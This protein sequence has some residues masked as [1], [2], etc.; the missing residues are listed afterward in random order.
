[1]KYQIVCLD[2]GSIVNDFKD[3]YRKG[4][5]CQKCGSIFVD[6][7][8][9]ATKDNLL[10]AL[11]DGSL[12][13]KGIWRYFDFLPLN[14]SNHQVSAGEG[15]VAVE[16]WPFLEDIAAKCG[17][18]IEVYAHRHDNNPATGT[19]KDLAGA[20]I[21]SVLK[22]AGVRSYAV[23]TTGNIGVALSRYLADADVSLHVFV[24]ENSSTL[25]DAEISCFGQKVFRVRGDYSDAKKMAAGFAKKYEIPL[26]PN[27]YDP[28][29]IEAKKTIAYEWY[30]QLEDF[31]TVYIQA[32]SGGTGPLGI[33]KG[34]KDL[35]E[36]GLINS[37][38]RFLMV[39]SDCCNPMEVSWNAAKQSGFKDG[40]EN[41]YSVISNPATTIPTLATGNPMLYPRVATLAK[42]SGGEILSYSESAIVD[43]ARFIAYEVAVRIGP[44]AAI[45]VGGFFNA[46]NRGYLRDGDRIVIAIGEGIRRSPQFMES[47]T[48]TSNTV[49]D[50]SD[51]YAVSRSDYG[52]MLKERIADLHNLPSITG[53]S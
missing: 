8:Y 39:Q 29:R 38:P 2:C 27:S 18:N 6:V 11:E 41:D 33:S 47:L 32:L 42:D 45:G 52:K 24:P 34:C 36:M 16:R 25:H 12:S 53:N 50:L 35:V 26:S 43:I 20:A 7:T 15:C 51:C 4:Q 30:R 23:A 14:S 17:L 37:I 28:I 48:Y 9:S 46:L 10:S 19:F 40:W 31:P 22:E 49:S 3:W 13:K 21:G 1:M 44:A 5:C